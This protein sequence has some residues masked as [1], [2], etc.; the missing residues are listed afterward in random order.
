MNKAV[1]ARD[2]GHQHVEAFCL[3]KYATK[4]R[5]EVEWI[6]NSRDGVTPFGL[7]SRSGKEMLHVDWHLD[8]YRPHYKP[9]NGERIFVD[10][11]P[12]RARELAVKKVEILWDHPEMPMS[13]HCP[14]K[15]TAAQMFVDSWT[16]HPG[17]LCVEEVKG[18]E[19]PRPWTSEDKV[20]DMAAHGNRAERRR[21]QKEDGPTEIYCHMH[22]LELPEQPVCGGPLTQP[23]LTEQYP[24]LDAAKEDLLAVV[25]ELLDYQYGGKGGLTATCRRAERALAEARKPHETH[26]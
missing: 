17:Q 14:D 7:L 15:E 25:L 12:E 11:T 20:A 13:G 2:F 19:P 22:S 10:L 1:N 16:E 26:Q 6:W 23:S 24:N 21:F 8:Q 5:S 4:D 3:M 18:A 9:R